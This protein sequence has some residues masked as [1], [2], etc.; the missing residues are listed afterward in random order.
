MS[1]IGE[2]KKVLQ[3]QTT[4]RFLSALKLISLRSHARK[5]TKAALL[6]PNPTTRTTSRNH[7]CYSVTDIGCVPRYTLIERKFT[8]RFSLSD[9]I[10]N[11]VS[12]MDKKTFRYAPYER[13]RPLK[14]FG[15]HSVCILTPERICTHLIANS[16][17]VRLCESLPKTA[18]YSAGEAFEDC[19][20]S[21]S[22]S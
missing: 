20:H 18:K 4:R 12:G 8:A 19:Q 9:R 22:I 17:A 1:V 7:Q 5:L 11:S 3:R 6:P 13:A 16:G 2:S 21:S 10:C 14:I 15:G